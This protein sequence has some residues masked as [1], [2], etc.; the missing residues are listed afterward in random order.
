MK[1][2]E[3]LSIIT[4]T[5]L[6]GFACG[7]AT[8]TAVDQ[9]AW[10]QTVQ[11]L[12]RAALDSSMIV[13]AK[14]NCTSEDAMRWWRGAEDLTKVREGLCSKNGQSQLKKLPQR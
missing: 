9:N 14:S 4:F 2:I 8:K 11:L 10:E 5:G 3:T 1:L 7:F 13:Q 6:F 12:N